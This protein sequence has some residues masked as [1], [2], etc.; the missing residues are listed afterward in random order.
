MSGEAF[1]QL[2]VEAPDA[3]AG[4]WVAAEAWELGAGGVEEVSNR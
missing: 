4:E 1:W 3:I 2:E